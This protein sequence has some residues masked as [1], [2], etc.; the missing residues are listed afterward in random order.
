MLTIDRKQNAGDDSFYFENRVYLFFM[1][2]K[3]CVRAFCFG[4]TPKLINDESLHDVWDAYLPDSGIKSGKFI[5]FYY[6]QDKNS[7][8]D[9]FMSE[10]E[11]LS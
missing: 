9:V 5:R 4:F 1:F 3:P 8:S 11:L 7:D 10:N 6:F 2:L